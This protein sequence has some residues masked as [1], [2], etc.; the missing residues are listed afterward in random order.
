MTLPHIYL[1]SGS[2]RRQELL[3]QI[4][5]NF[6]TLSVEVDETYQQGELPE[7]YVTRLAIAKA[8]AGWRSDKRITMYPVLGADTSVVVNGT[9]FGK[10]KNKVDARKMLMS[11]SGQTHQ[12][13]T[14]VALVTEHAVLTSVSHNSVTFS[15][16]TDAEI[17]WYISTGEGNDKAGGYAVQ[18]L[19][20]M[21]I[22]SINGSYS[23][24]MGLPVRET[25]QLLLQLNERKQ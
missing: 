2:P 6:S 21:F 1:A 17:D 20:A 12:V 19:S 14:G 13:I 7:V 16:L 11:L 22:D 5:V 15:S 3:T 23:G 18:G 8:Q 10:P 9:V 24:I 4:G 25:Y